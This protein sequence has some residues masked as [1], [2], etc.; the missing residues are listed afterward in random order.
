MNKA[1]VFSI[2]EFSTFDGPGIRTTVFLKGCPLK[3]EW[4]HNPEG[5]AFGNELIKAQAGCISCGKCEDVA[6]D[7]KIF[8][9]PNN[10]YRLAARE[11]SSSQLAEKLLKNAD[12]FNMSGGGVTFSGG[13]PLAQYDFLKDCLPKLKGKVHIALQ[14]SGFCEGEKFKEILS[15]CDYLLYD[16]KIVDSQLHKKYTGV[17]NLV[18]LEN[19]KT[20]TLSGREFVIRT[21][22]IPGVTDTNE[23]LQNIAE[24]LSENGIKSIDLMPY[25]ELTGS[26]YAAVGREYN[27]TFNENRPLNYGKEIFK[28]YGITANVL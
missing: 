11:Y 28:K 18:I 7:E 2:E 26:K 13:E 17:S 6:G 3:C 9:C 19:L 27:P 14:T 25:H 24:L 23:N 1:L 10:L 5:Q 12:I 15:L 20:L 8:A 16:I 4:C 21:P 22:L